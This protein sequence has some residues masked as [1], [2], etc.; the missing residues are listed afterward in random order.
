MFDKILLLRNKGYVPDIIFDIGAHKGTWTQSCLQIYPRRSYLL[1]EAI[2]YQELK[3]FQAPNISVFNEVLNDKIEEVEWFEMQNTGDSMFKEKSI[4]FKDCVPLKKITNTLDN[5]IETNKNII[6]IDNIKNV[7]IK[8]DCQ[9]A[10][11]PILKGASN[12]LKKTDFI[13]LEIP[14]F[15]QYNENVPSFIEHINFMNSIG[16]VTY[17]IADNHYINGFN[18]QVD[19]LFINKNHSFN[20]IVNELLLK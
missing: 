18:M 7:F 12:I 13:I 4:H 3:L 14:L 11:I 20:T 19:V 17:D 15:G 9:G 5:I 2:D 8:I 1:F 10:E 6:D 16:F